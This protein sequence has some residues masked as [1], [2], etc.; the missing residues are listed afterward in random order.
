[1]ATTKYR[2]RQ[3]KREL[4]P[5]KRHELLTGEIVRN[6]EYS[7]YADPEGTS[8]D[9]TQFISDE[10]RRDWEDNRDELL[11][12]WKSGESTADFFV[13]SRPWLHEYGDPNDLP[14]AEK[15][16]RNEQAPSK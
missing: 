3:S 6:D 5:Y 2:T 16:F 15:H 11:E 9:L 12:F 8:E 13:D 7:G 14:W 10:M 1:M 4:G